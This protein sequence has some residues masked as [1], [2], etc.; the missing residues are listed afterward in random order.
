MRSFV[1]IRGL[2][3]SSRLPRDREFQQRQKQKTA[4]RCGFS[5]WAPGPA[6]QA[7][8]YLA[9]APAAASALA[10]AASAAGAAASAAGAAAGASAA[11]AGAA[12]GASAAGAGAAGAGASA[13]GAGAGAGAASSFLPQ[14][15]RAAAAI[16]VARM[17]EFFITISSSR[18]SKQYLHR[19]YGQLVA[20]IDRF[21]RSRQTV[22]STRIA[23]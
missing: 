19:H 1:G 17:R 8:N 22:N 7:T 6:L 3:T 21:G 20:A 23:L 13:A 18:F 4:P 16:T 12:A 2:N 9:A 14:A 10:L 15:A 11:G 5:A